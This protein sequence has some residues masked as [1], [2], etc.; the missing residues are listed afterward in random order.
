M[1]PWLVGV[2]LVVATGDWIAV[3]RGSRRAELALKPAV[4]ILLAAAAVGLRHDDPTLR[5]AFTALAMLLSLAGDVFLMLPGDLF[6]AGLGS[7]LLAHVC[8]V[9]AL[10]TPRTPGPS[11]GVAL[12]LALGVALVSTPLWLRI[13]AALARSG[14]DSL[15]PPVTAYVIAIS[16]MVTFA[17]ATAFRPGWT[18]SRSALAIGGA[19]LFYTSDGMIGWSRFVRDFPGSRTAITVTYHL[20]QIGL[21]LGLL[22][23]K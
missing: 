17:L 12:V 4:M 22:G 3:A 21:L 15:A 18:A 8:Y 20:G 14:R 11:P 19:L 7:F 9:V 23:G 5:F 13:R 6:V 10:D 16:A 1:G 2:A